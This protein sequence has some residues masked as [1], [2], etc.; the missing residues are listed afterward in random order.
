MKRFDPVA[1]SGNAV[2]PPGVTPEMLQADP[3][4]FR[5][6]WVN[7]AT[8]WENLEKALALS[9]K[10]GPNEQPMADQARA[11]LALYNSDPAYKALLDD[12]YLG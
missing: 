6:Q 10:V 12:M 11:L 5:P 2:Y 7:P 9:P 8:F 4:A 1:I 3:E